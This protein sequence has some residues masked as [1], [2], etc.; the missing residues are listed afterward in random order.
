LIHTVSADGNVFTSISWAPGRADLQDVQAFTRGLARY[1]AS[2]AN[3]VLVVDPHNGR[4]ARSAARD[5]AN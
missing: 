1:A 3:F 2:N 5:T 4:A